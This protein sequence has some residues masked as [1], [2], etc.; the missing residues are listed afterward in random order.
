M[1]AT[2]AGMIKTKSVTALMHI[3]WPGISNDT[4]QCIRQC[5]KCQ[6]F[7]NDPGRASLHPWETPTEVRH[8]WERVH[9]DFARPFKGKMWIIIVDAFSKWS[10][11]IQL[12]TTT[13]EK[14]VEIYVHCFQ[15]MA[16][17]EPLQAIMDLNLLLPYSRHS[18]R[19]VEF[20]INALL[21]TTTVLT[22]K[23]NVLYSHL[24]QA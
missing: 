14:T 5:K 8:A 13:A 20:V 4:E 17:L 3:W 6:I 22:E 23:Q 24:R 15:D 7:K 16:C 1:I 21:H 9:I 2:H 10:E 11:V 18:A 19:T 12:A